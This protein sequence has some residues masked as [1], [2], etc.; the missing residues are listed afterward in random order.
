[1]KKYIFLLQFF[2]AG[3]LILS[4][5]SC[6]KDGRFAD[7]YIN[8]STDS[9]TVGRVATHEK[10][11]IETNVSLISVIS[12]DDWC[13][14]KLT[15]TELSI[16]IDANDDDARKGEI[17]LKGRGVEKRI[18]INQ[19]GL[20]SPPTGTIGADILISVASATTTSFHSAN[21]IDL[22]F[23][24]DFDTY[25]M[26]HWSQASFP[27]EVIY[28]FTNVE[29][30][31]YI[32]YYPRP[33][34]AGKNGLLNEVEV[35]YATE[36]NPSFT[37]LRDYNFN[38]SPSS[39]KIDLPNLI[40]PKQIKFVLSKGVGSGTFAA[41]GEMQF[42]QN[43]PDSFDYLSI[44]TD[45]SCSQLKDEI[46][47]S[48]IENISHPFFKYLAAELYHKEYDAE[49]RV[50]EYRAC[51]HP[52]VM[53]DINKTS[54]YS[55]LD[56]PT[57]ISVKTGEELIVLANDPGQNPIS[58]QVIDLE[59]GYSSSSSYSIS[60]GV[61]KFKMLSKGLAYIM[62]HTDSGTE[63]PVK[64]N[65]ATG[66]VNGYFDS[67]KHTQQDW[68]RLLD[69][70]TDKHFDVL[71]KYCHLTFPVADFK[72][73]TSDGFALVKKY[74]E[75]M[76]LESEFMGLIKYKKTFNNR[77]YFHIDYGDTYM[78][79][80]AY[81]TGYSAGTMQ[82]MCNLETFTTNCWG[83]AHEVGHVNQTRP[84]LRW[85][86]MTEV[87]NNLH[88]LF[89]QKAFG[90][91]SRLIKDGVYDKAFT[92]SG[93]ILNSNK[94]FAESTDLFE[95]LVPFWQLKLYLVD[96]IGKSEFYK[97]LYE[98]YRITATLSAQQTDGVYQLDFVRSVC[99]VANLDLTDFFDKWGFL[100][101]VDIEVN[102]YNS[103]RFTITKEQIDQ[104]K[105]E[106]KAKNYPK[107]KHSDIYKITD[108]NVANYSN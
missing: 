46:T 40:R 31:D 76:V 96:A 20:Q 28:S 102:D 50:Q 100:H 79:A 54:T 23:D 11:E 12:S 22:S 72:K 39:V 107:P 73:H 34:G 32:I 98:H 60:K 81:R 67:E 93:S 74:D 2:V 66:T 57:G 25:F 89:V 24:G 68:K 1:M 52:R 80:T 94:A 36:A 19:R 17:L 95:K 75:L 108:S 29:A 78:Y 77:M 90:N 91:T 48:T 44:F 14:V 13:Q 47:L 49:F 87:T 41:I 92:N 18:I 38:G 71:G 56:N 101:A 42:F 10:I 99:K 45:H 85:Q 65:I 33:G 16:E 3:V 82:I 58:L 69:K 84:G 21:P 27:V 103:K 43:N 7:P 53:S 8:P 88:S 64:I 70:A 30:M 105:A 51:Q 83:P 97:D 55:L 62:Y 35:W 63:K 6:K 86:G 5:F 15:D 59:N 61:N 104:L 9:L 106:I 4:L 37:K 26:T